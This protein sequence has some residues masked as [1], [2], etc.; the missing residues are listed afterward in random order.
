MVPRKLLPALALTALLAT[1]CASDENPLAPTSTGA[2]TTPPASPQ[3]LTQHTDQGGYRIS[4]AASADADLAG[5]NV[6]RYDPDP[7]RVSAWVKINGS[8][9]TGTTHSVMVAPGEWNYAVRSVDQSGNE[10][11]L[12][13]FITVSFGQMTGDI[14]DG[15]EIKRGN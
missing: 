5:Y 12:S 3:S 14:G 4:W 8:L 1:G 10:S 7:S 2:D 11:P 13:S 15:D 6:Y 9:V